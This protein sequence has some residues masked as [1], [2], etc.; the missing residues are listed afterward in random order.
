M[1]PDG[2]NVR[3]LVQGSFATNPSWSPDGSRIAFDDGSTVY[4]VAADGSGL[5]RLAAGSNPAWSPDDSTIA[6]ESPTEDDGVF[7]LF[8][9]QPA[10]G[11]IARLTN[12]PG[13]DQAPAFS[14]GGTIVFVSA[15]T[16]RLELWTMDGDGSGQRSLGATGFDPAWSPD[17]SQIVFAREGQ[18]W[19]IL[20]DGTQPRQLTTNAL[21]AAAPAWQPLP[22]PTGACT[23]W[24]TPANDLLVGT[25]GR[26]VLCGYAGD[27][28]LVGLAGPD[29][30]DG[31]PGN[32]RLAGGLGADG[33]FAGDG[34]DSIDARDG[35]LDTFDGGA[36]FDRAL[37]DGA[38]D[39]GVAERRVRD[40]NLTVWR[41]TTASH[42]EPGSPSMLAVDGRYD[43]AWS[44]G[45][46][47][48]QWLEVD[49]Q[50]PVTIA[51]LRLIAPDLPSGAALVVLARND[52][53]SYRLL[54]RFSGPT[55]FTQ[56]VSF[57][58]RHPWR[59]VRWLRLYVPAG[60]FSGWVSCPELEAYAF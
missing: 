28:T 13:L 7:D 51:R 20:A 8:S 37:V 25:P 18:L 48:P 41:P 45:G 40:G 10:T 22:P 44:S 19:S 32:D 59:K 58:P 33:L 12:T 43:D 56:A 15:R 23:L 14:P 50:R 26:D 46:Y 52:D 38:A 36:G 5:T 3:P 16:G 57:R 49:L 55:V 2:T 54:H 39:F 31:G 60:S 4:T 27:D 6:F 34:D 29:D 30:A 1:D 53:G 35:G 9:I 11:H 42:D 17:G 47:P 24:G 21:G